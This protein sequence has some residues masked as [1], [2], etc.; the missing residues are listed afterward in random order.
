M[1]TA[2]TGNISTISDESLQGLK[3]LEKDGIV[4]LDA[5]YVSACEPSFQE[6]VIQFD[7]NQHNVVSLNLGTKRIRNIDITAF[8]HFPYLQTLNL[9]GTDLPVAEVMNILAKVAP[10]IQHLFLGGL[11]L[12]DEGAIAVTQFLSSATQLIKIDLR[13]NDIGAA[14]LQGWP[15][16]PN[17]LRFLYLEGN[18]LQDAGAT[19][20]ATLLESSNVEQVFLGANR[21][22]PAGAQALAHILPH[23]QITKL[24]LEGNRIGIEG[25]EHFINALERDRSSIILQHLYADNNDIGKESSKRL[26]KALNLESM[27]DDAS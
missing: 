9:G 19:T 22:G 10:S 26:A 12:R 25:A 17:T 6:P 24:Y 20:L 18:N 8:D 2:A 3:K 14:G 11:G 7:N 13:Y 16:L 15:S 4:S 23:S 5:V 21:I 27:I 1:T